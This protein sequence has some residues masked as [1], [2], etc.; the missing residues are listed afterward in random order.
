MVDIFINKD[1]VSLQFKILHISLC[2]KHQQRSE[3][4]L[5]A[6]LVNSDRLF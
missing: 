5:I 2:E 4:E 3:H 6:Q 1:L